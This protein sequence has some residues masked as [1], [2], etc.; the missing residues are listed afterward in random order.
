MSNFNKSRIY[1]ISS[2]I[3]IISLFTYDG[4]YATNTLSLQD[5][6]DKTGVVSQND[7]VDTSV[8]HNALARGGKTGKAIAFSIAKSIYDRYVHIGTINEVFDDILQDHSEAH[9]SSL[10]DSYYRTSEKSTIDNIIKLTVENPD[11]Y[12]FY[13]TNTKCELAV[14]KKFSETECQQLIGKNNLGYDNATKTYVNYSVVC[15]GINGIKKE[16]GKPYWTGKSSLNT[17]YP[18][19]R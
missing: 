19:N 12:E 1:I 14:V 13:G 10:S 17:A 6:I 2:I 16:T 9:K 5:L 7:G 8:V 15:F 4:C 18:R 11:Y 3:L